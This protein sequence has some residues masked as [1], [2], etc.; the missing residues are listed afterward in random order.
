MPVSLALVM[1]IVVAAIM[2]LIALPI[3]TSLSDSIICPVS[4]TNSTNTFENTCE[5]LKSNTWIVFAILPIALF[6]AIFRI[7]A[8]STFDSDDQ[9]MTTVTGKKAKRSEMLYWKVLLFLKIAK[10]KETGK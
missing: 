9:T 6:F 8:F 4:N 3:F 7:F 10:I 2:F 1:G 5:S